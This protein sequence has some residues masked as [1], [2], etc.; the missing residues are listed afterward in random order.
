[1]IL[2]GSDSTRYD[3]LKTDLANDIMKGSDNILKTIV[4]LVELFNNYK[5]PR[6]HQCN[7]EPDGNGV[8]FVQGNRQLAA[9]KS[10]IEC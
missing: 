5:V 6:R 3:Q 4:G 1:M 7:Q 2:W 8:A 10:K 9:P